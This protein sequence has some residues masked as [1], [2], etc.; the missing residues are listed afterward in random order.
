MAKKRTTAKKQEAPQKINFAI[1]LELSKKQTF[2]VYA[3]I[4]LLSAGIALY[5]IIEA[6]SINKTYG[7]PLDDPWIHL[8]FAKNLAQYHSFS[9]FKSEMS[10]AGSTSP[11][12]TI[13][14]AAG[15]F[16]TKNEFALSYALGILFFAF[17]AYMFFR[18]CREEFR[19]ETLMAIICAII[20][21][22]DRWMS[23]I[24]DSGMETT[25][26]I[27]IL[28]SCA[29]FYRQRQAVPFAIFTGL[30][31][32][33]RPDGIAFIGALAVDYLILQYYIKPDGKGIRLFTRQE[34]IRAG[35]V[36]GGILALY[37]VMNLML[38]GSLLPNTYNAKITYYSPEF[39]SRSSFLKGEVWDYFRDGTSYSLLMIGFLCSVI[40]AFYDLVRKKY[41]GNILYIVFIL[42]LVFLYWYKL[43]YAHRFGR[44][45]MPIIPYYI[46]TSVT[47]YRDISRMIGGYLKSRQAAAAI[48]FIAV[49]I[50]AVTSVPKL[51][52]NKNSY[53]EECRYIG[54]RQVAAAYWLRDNTKETDVI[55]THD[56]GAI[57]YYSGR[58]IVDLA[59]LVSPELINK[60]LDINYVNQARDFMK[61]QGVTHLAVLQE[62]F[63]V[64]NQTPLFTT[65]DKT[66]P[67]GETMEIYKFNPES[68]HILRGDVKD[69]VMYAQTSLSQKNIQQAIQVLNQAASTDPKASLVYYMLA[70]AYSLSGNSKETE[71]N[72]RKAVD[73][74]P[75]YKDALLQLSSY[76]RSQNNKPE[77]RKYITHYLELNPNNTKALEL[78]NSLGD[79]LQ[80]K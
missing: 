61:Q 70:A 64:V 50:I 34:L 43:P 65:A 10:T 44:Y 73:I 49:I 69:M 53:A 30:I 15:F 55:A 56:I 72:L 74:Y 59:G 33:T 26:F 4:L 19:P 54:E 68:T 79:T 58:K 47:G 18:L 6:K 66:A 28:I 51:I 3:L 40:L 78:L 8:T 20:F 76:Y 37:F 11:L 60:L 24:A 29:Y 42:A 63:R 39:R 21:I 2:T 45:L 12:Y 9:Y 13:I 27:F 52:E 23:F 77:A 7:F 32:W 46:L 14:L 38:S 67:G 71:K 75:D 48:F 17:S 5:F 16:I 57:G 80:T 1:P 22:I 31:I 41:N 36:T 35:I 25:M 62:W